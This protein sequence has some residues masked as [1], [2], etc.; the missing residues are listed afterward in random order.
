MECKRRSTK[1]KTKPK[2]IFETAGPIALNLTRPDKHDRGICTN[3]HLQTDLDVEKRTFSIINL[4]HSN[5]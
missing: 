4:L 1:S 5:C 2:V 3:H